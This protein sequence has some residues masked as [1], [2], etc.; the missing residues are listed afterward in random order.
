MLHILAFSIHY[1]SAIFKN[2]DH[3]QLSI[4][5]YFCFCL[6]FNAHALI[7]LRKNNVNME[8]IY[9]E[10]PI[11]AFSNAFSLLNK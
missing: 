7:A 8:K 9:C 3:D 4:S 10:I 5:Q 11:A 1:E 6:P 2:I